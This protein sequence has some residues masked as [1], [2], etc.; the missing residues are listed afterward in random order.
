MRWTNGC[1]NTH[2]YIFRELLL[3]LLNI[4]SLVDG[5][6]GCGAYLYKYICRIIKTN[7]KDI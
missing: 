2:S 7:Y 1:K 3:S 5:G 4:P 6:C